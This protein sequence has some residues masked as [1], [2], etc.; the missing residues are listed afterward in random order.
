MSES[1]LLNDHG[2]RVVVHQRH[3]NDRL[4]AH[5]NQPIEADGDCG[6]LTIRQSAFAAW[7]LGALDT[8]VKAVQGGTI[9]VGVQSIIADPD[10]REDAQRERA[11]ARRDQHFP[12]ANGNVAAPLHKIITSAHG[13][14]PG[15][16]GVDLICE[17]NAPI[18]AL[19]DAKVIDV[20]SR[21]WWGLGA[22]PSHGHPIS[23]GDG[24]IQLEC[25]IDD[26]PFRKGMH[27][28]YGH[29]EHATVAVGQTVKAGQQLGRAGFANAWHVHFMA[30]GGATHRGVGD[31]NP[32][33]FVNY[34]MQ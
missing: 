17:A 2:E 27:F 22:Q 19:C 6:P 13:F 29:A 30:N 28:G 21:G 3:V 18:F 15:H 1:I 33:P 26:G 4:R 8:T 24:I 16:D 14:G 23:D 20:R 7:F 12:G 32:M 34:A 11:R 9:S 25:L 5:G 10:S 31:R